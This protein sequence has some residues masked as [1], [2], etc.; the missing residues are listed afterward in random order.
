MST[1][2]FC[3][4]VILV[5]IG[6]DIRLLTL[7]KY[8]TLQLYQTCRTELLTVHLQVY[9]QHKKIKTVHCNCYRITAQGKNSSDNHDY[10]SVYPSSLKM[11]ILTICH[12]LHCNIMFHLKIVQMFG[13]FSI[14]LCY[15]ICQKMKTLL[16]R[17]LY[18]RPH[19]VFM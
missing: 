3:S 13:A 8:K 4:N 12:Y 19:H 14:L 5:L 11:F 1:L 17:L 16:Y 15:S 7:K 18:R 10:S 9:E 2:G 6:L